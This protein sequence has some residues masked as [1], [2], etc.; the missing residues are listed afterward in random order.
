MSYNAN[1]RK[2]FQTL[3]LARLA[4]YHYYVRSD[5][6]RYCE[7]AR[8]SSEELAVEDNGTGDDKLLQFDTRKH[9]IFQRAHQTAF[10]D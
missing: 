3:V 4:P 10:E 7:D 1:V 2:F 8:K 5:M 9:S 6:F